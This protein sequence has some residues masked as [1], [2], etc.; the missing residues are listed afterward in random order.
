[1]FNYRDERIYTCEKCKREISYYREEC[2][3]TGMDWSGEWGHSEDC[4]KEEN[5]TTQPQIPEGCCEYCLEP[6]EYCLCG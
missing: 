4:G 3:V 2:G 6:V 5:N 1:M